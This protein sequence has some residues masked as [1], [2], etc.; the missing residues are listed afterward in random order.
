MEGK[1]EID[2]LHLECVNINDD[3]LRFNIPMDNLIVVA[4]FDPH[5]DVR[6]QIFNLWEGDVEFHTNEGHEIDSLE[7]LHEDDKLFIG[8]VEF[9][10]LV[11]VVALS[12]EG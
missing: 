10:K 11:N 4:F 12:E 7:V 9:S 1:S 6:Q 8:F 2:N 3:V 5:E